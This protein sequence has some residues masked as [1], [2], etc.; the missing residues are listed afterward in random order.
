M[1]LKYGTEEK[2]AQLSMAMLEIAT[3]VYYGKYFAELC[4]TLEG[5]FEMILRG[6]AVFERLEATIGI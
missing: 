1:I 6:S 4:H 2:S 3:V 5:Y